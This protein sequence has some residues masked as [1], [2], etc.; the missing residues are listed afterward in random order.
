MLPTN[1]ELKMAI[2]S[3]FDLYTIT[4]LSFLDLAY[5]MKIRPNVY[6]IVRD[7]F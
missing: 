2:K 1:S 4:N 3:K 7:N 6:A 5:G